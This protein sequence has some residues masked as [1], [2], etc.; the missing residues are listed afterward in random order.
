ML[1]SKLDGRVVICVF[2]SI[3]SRQIQSLK[4]QLQKV[5]HIAEC[6]E[7]DGR[8]LVFSRIWMNRSVPD[9][10]SP[11][12]ALGNLKSPRSSLQTASPDSSHPL[13]R[14]SRLLSPVAFGLRR[15]SPETQTRP[16]WDCH[17]GL[18][19]KRPGVVDWRSMGRQ[20]K[21]SPKQVVSGRCQTPWS[22]HDS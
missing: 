11:L 5:H 3:H 2:P 18:P 14:S 17:V 12:Q 21:G 13:R 22:G 20:S 19:E 4:Q 10:D 8:S 16:V 7:I 9:M 6:F 15:G 1:L